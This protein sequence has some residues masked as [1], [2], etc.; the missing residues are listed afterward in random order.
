MLGLGKTTANLLH[1]RKKWQTLMGAAGKIGLKMS[2]FGQGSSRLREIYDFGSNPG[3][4]RM[5]THL[6][7]GLADQSALVVVLHGCAQTAASYDHGTGWSTLA[8]RYGFALLLPEQQHANNPNGCFNWF[9]PGDTER[10]QG[11]A[12]SIRQMV[13]KMALD[14]GI[15]RRRVYVTGLSAGGA[16]ASVMLAT[17]PDVF[18]GGA[19]I[20]GLPYGAATNVQEAFESMFQSPPRPAGLWGDLVRRASPHQGP[21]PRVSVWH[22]GMDTT[23]VPPNAAEIVKQWTN[24]HGLPTAPTLQETV[25][26]YPRQVWRNAEG[27]DLIESYAIPSMSHGTP[28]SVGD[29]DDQCGAAGAFLLEV[30]ISSSYHVAKFWGL[31]EAPHDA[32]KDQASFERASRRSHDIAGDERPEKPPFADPA[33]EPRSVPVDIRAVITQA[34]RAAGLM[35]AD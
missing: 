23:V 5:F 27:E 4:L 17:Y 21:W 12:L 18:A 24:V 1:D 34:L 8:G 6:P 16:M 3:A 2:D 20:A 10:G 14:H 13:D 22:G 25:D 15:D 26:G 32:A 11:E 31:A 29:A 33:G 9:Q 35:K 28:L 19:I 30:G 7:S